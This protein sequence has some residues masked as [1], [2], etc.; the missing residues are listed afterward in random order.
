MAE[1]IELNKEYILQKIQNILN[2]NH[3]IPEKKKMKVSETCVAMACPICG[4]SAKYS[5][6]HK[7]RGTLYWKNLHYICFN[8]GCSHSITSFFKLFEEEIDIDEKIKLYNYIDENTIVSNINNDYIT[9]EMDKLIDVEDFMN[10]FNNRKNSWLYDVKPIE[11]NSHVDQYLKYS[12]LLTNTNQIYQG[13]YR[14]IKNEKTVF[15]TRVMILMNMSLSTNKLLGIQL[16]NLESNKD[17]RFYKI[18]E[19]EELYNYMNQ[20]P[21]DE[22]ESISYNKLS[23]I[24]NILNINFEN[25]VTIF[26]G[27]IDSLFYSFGNSIGIIGTNSS[28]DLLNFFMNVD[29][30]IKLQF[31]LDNDVAGL[32]LATKIIKKYPNYKV[33]LWNKLF[34]KL[35][36][37]K[38][39]N[40]KEKL[41]DIVDLND[42]VIKSKNK[43]IAKKLKL[44]KFF[45]QDEFDLLYLNKIIG[46]KDKN[47]KTQ[48]NIKNKNL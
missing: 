48:W 17:K 24:Y 10:Y 4:D 32:L 42:L 18:V 39:Y 11:N 26:E 41:K 34:E 23:H 45:S 1:K 37:K 28:E 2:K 3:T 12:R 15:E 20:T 47:G 38:G 25:P 29:N 27:F 14:I 5:G 44:D 46:E 13:I 8:E 19:F 21:L 6:K 16:R 33:F 7:K 9:T 43:N 40:A 22:L 35:S 31:F 36:E 30:E